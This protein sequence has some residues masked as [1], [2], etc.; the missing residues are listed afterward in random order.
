MGTAARAEHPLHKGFSWAL[1]Q[2]AMLHLVI[3]FLAVLGEPPCK[4]VQRPNSQALWID[5]T[6]H[7]PRNFTG[8]GVSPQL[9]N[10]FS[11]CF[12]EQTL[13]HG[14]KPWLLR[15]PL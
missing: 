7:L 3:D 13:N 12:P 5:L 6:R 14:P 9:L 15:R 1:K 11:R 8:L 4:G 2:R 10:H